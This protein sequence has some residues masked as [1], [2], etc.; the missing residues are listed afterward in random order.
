MFV[1][2]DFTNAF[3]C[4]DRQALLEQCRHHFPGLSLWAEWC[5]KQPS[6]LYFGSEVISSERGVQQGD[7]LGPLL[8][9]LAIQPLLLQ[10]HEGKAEQGLQ[11]SYSYLDD[12]ILAGDQRAVSEA[13]SFFK[14][15]AS[16]IGLE[17]NTAKCEVI[18]VAGAKLHWIKAYS[19]TTSL[20]EKMAISSYWVDPS[21]LKNFALTTHRKGL[22][23]P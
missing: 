11:L 3:N 4:V 15:V 13:F 10:L 9:A 6:K 23:K 1:K 22:I 21:A 7:P 5:Y 19:L 14:R 20:T 8:F 17:F 12:L 2:V 18:P 16:Q